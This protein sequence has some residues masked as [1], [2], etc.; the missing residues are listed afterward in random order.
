M[1]GGGRERQSWEGED[2]GKEKKIIGRLAAGKDESEGVMKKGREE[3]G[4]IG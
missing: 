1:E 4:K 3:R 2:V